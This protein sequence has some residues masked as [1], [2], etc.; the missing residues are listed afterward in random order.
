MYA[1]DIVDIVIDQRGAR[2]HV[3][4]ITKSRDF[5]EFGCVPE[6][7]TSLATKVDLFQPLSPLL[8]L[9]LTLLSLHNSI[10]HVG[11]KARVQWTAF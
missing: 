6:S 2:G 11:D 10:N 7:V 8:S 5:D 4:G 3:P 9:S 1:L